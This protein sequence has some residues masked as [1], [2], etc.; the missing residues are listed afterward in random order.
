MIAWSPIGQRNANVWYSRK[1]GL[2]II[3]LDSP[4]NPPRRLRHG[5]SWNV[6][7][8]QWSPFAARDYWIASTSNQK[9]IVWNLTMSEDGKQG[10][11]EHTLQ[12][13]TR[14]ITDINFSA[15]HPDI[16]ST[17]AVDGYVHCWDLRRPRRPVMTFVDWD[18]G[19]TQV[20][21]NRQ[22]G[23]I[24]A[25]SHDRWLRIWD[26]RKGAYPL[27]SIEAHK[28]K[29]YGVDWNRTRT[30]GI[31]TCSLDKTI[32][33][34]DYNNELDVPERE[35]ETNFPVWRARHTPFGW[36]LLAMPQDL[37][38]NLYLYDRRKAGQASDLS[39]ATST[40]FQGH[41][42]KQ[43][44]EFLWRGRG[45]INDDGIDNRE[46][47]L[48]TW[49]QDKQLRLHRV[50]AKAL[51]GVGFLKG[52]QVRKKLNVT[53]KGAVY[54]TFRNVDK[55]QGEKKNMTIRGL[56]P[57][58]S[59]IDTTTSALSESMNKMPP[60][61]SPRAQRGLHGS[62]MKGKAV[63]TDKRSQIGW[64]RGIKFNSPAPDDT[65]NR[66]P[67]S[68]RRYSLLSPDFDGHGE[69]DTP[70]SLHDEIIHVSKQ[71]TRV[72][73]D[74]VNMDKRTVTVS[75]NGPWGENGDSVFLR[76]LI[77][78]PEKY[79]DDKIPPLFTVSRGLQISDEVYVKI[80][81]EVE[82]IAAGVVG[83]R[84][85]C[86]E[87]TL[88]Y[89]LGE[90]DL[91]ES[92]MWL[93][94]SQDVDDD[95]I[96][97]LA[98]ESSSEDDDSDMPA[99][100]SAMMSQELDPNAGEALIPVHRHANVPLPRLCGAKFGANGKLVCFFRPKEETVKS[101]LGTVNI[102]R[103]RPRGEPY[104]NS[105]AR[106]RSEANAPKSKLASAT[107][108]DDDSEGNSSM[109]SEDSDSSSST[110]SNSS[111]FRGGVAFDFWRK[112]HGGNY[113][114][115]LS[116]NRSHSSNA[117]TGTGTGTA[118]SKARS[119]KPKNTLSIHDI[120]EHIP[121]KFELA[122]EYAIF[123]DGADVCNHN[124]AMAE[125]YGYS[126]RADVWRYA[127]ML[128]QHEVPLEVLEQ[129]H[130]KEP[131]LVIAREM[132]KRCRR[133]SGSDSGVDL[134]SDMPSSRDSISGR[135]KWG[136]NPLAKSLIDDLFDYFEKMAD[137]QMLAMLSCIFSEPSA[138]EG[139]LQ[140]EMRLTQPQ[141]PLSMKTPGF[142]LEYFP[143]DAAA[144]S[145]YHKTPYG[146]VVSTP[147]IAYTPT[148]LFG[149]LGS[150][151]GG[152]WSGDPA[153]NSHSCGNTPPSRSARESS[154]KLP[155]S[156]SLSA[157]PEETR[158]FKRVQSSTLASTFAASFT[159]SFAATAPSSPPNR[160]R[161]SPVESVANSF[162]QGV[163]W[164]NTTILESVREAY[165]GRTSYSDDDAFLEDKKPMPV[166]GISIVIHNQHAF[167]DEGCMSTSLLD[168]SHAALFSRYRRQYS[169]LLYQ[170][171]FQL[172][173]LE[174]L[175]F[176]SLPDHFA[177]SHPG[178][179]TV[180]K[181]FEASV[182]SIPERNSI[183]G[184][185]PPSPILLG[186]REA[187]S[188]DSRMQGL[189]IAGYCLKHEYRLEPLPAGSPPA[190]GAVGRCE[191]CK[192]VKTQLHCVICDEPVSEVY[193][194]CLSC[195]CVSHKR[196]LVEYHEAGDTLCPGG[197]DCDCSVKAGKGTVESWEVMM[198][199][200]ER[201]RKLHGSGKHRKSDSSWDGPEKGDWEK[202]MPPES[203]L[204]Q[205][206]SPGFGRGYPGIGRRLG[207]VSG[208][209]RKG[210]ILRRDEGV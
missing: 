88:C 75:M 37:P 186:K 79:P 74:N 29:I 32:K 143:T 87:A 207:Q 157:S 190:G 43:V 70:E 162:A 35:I 165:S 6:A 156:Q 55:P 30:S 8:V 81:N 24:L 138:P 47:Q 104:F 73:F 9:A 205:P 63:L 42:D 99:G 191:R 119:I 102:G 128:L 18:A 48:V 206:P 46:F 7:D 208:L 198:G 192:M 84:R 103:D 92:A 26:D 158:G 1:F 160:K 204:V 50:D 14:A 82:Q 171:G 62:A 93:T 33:F 149:S 59:G 137:V 136:Y 134:S 90:V 106:L 133:D 114:K 124:A 117:G 36:G 16:L 135:V 108:V 116:T 113:R 193:V 2:D 169:E 118:H 210:S 34:W 19:A 10:A 178:S 38:G 189:D 71:F 177:Q 65:Q 12:A 21:W 161:P 52:T 182:A 64:M 72:N 111:Q 54:K 15:H 184:I 179:P 200:I 163:T 22:D 173:R 101:L 44:K 139:V 125:K 164:G 107:D 183:V 11:I 209:R 86:L 51:E 57:W 141:T 85:G 126:D 58:S 199:A 176:D 23:H 168:F 78:F 159:R 142:S 98:D 140:P 174:V 152:A 201:M 83:R 60:P 170:W 45:S 4:L 148:G 67:L 89:L 180:S 94:G 53:R 166:T 115:T 196:C 91:E 109:S 146:S 68:G 27:R 153:S 121:A 41:G 122:D 172:A 130:R 49:G 17:C 105:F 203:P 13:H 145:T 132:V 39:T 151:N 188:A 40:V 96:N 3:D 100:T 181:P 194:P 31:V 110:D 25:S 175:K 129:V 77:S 56:R 144:W 147:K 20:K 66:K 155:L 76:V 131:I 150:S 195:G 5:Q 69:W 127:A 154:E 123:G 61:K 97:A 120:K 80:V 202:L 197:C 187:P 185:G 95:D 28:S 167:D 112:M